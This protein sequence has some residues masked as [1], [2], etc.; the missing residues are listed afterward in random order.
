MLAVTEDFRR[1]KVFNKIL[2]AL[3][4]YPV[5]S[6]HSRGEQTTAHE[7]AP[8][9]VPTA[10][11]VEKGHLTVGTARGAIRKTRDLPAFSITRSLITV[12]QYRGCVASGA[13]TPPELTT[14]SCSSSENGLD[15]RTYDAKS[16]VEDAPVTC[17][18]AAQAGAYCR[19]V[20]G[21]LPTVDEWLLAARGPDIHRFAWGD[22]RPSCEKQWRIAFGSRKG[23]CCDS[24]CDD[25]SAATTGKHPAGQSP[26]GLADVLVTFAEMASGDDKSAWGAC[27]KGSATCVA[28]GD[29][30]GAIDYFVPLPPK[31][32]AISAGFRCAWEAK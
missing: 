19:W 23:A 26:L 5:A 11:A 12:A 16:A 22:A 8:D 18:T 21:R 9:Q 15:G 14:G 2:L 3:L 20:R 10:I 24:K 32:L 7:A 30:P 31:E 28:K 13:C 4:I 29:E 1:S 25:L 27:G 6:C 17:T